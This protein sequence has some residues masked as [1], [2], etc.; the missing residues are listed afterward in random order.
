MRDIKT[1]T[2]QDVHLD[3]LMKDFET[4][5]RDLR[6]DCSDGRI[7]TCIQKQVNLVEGIV[8]Q[9]PGVKHDN[10]SRICDELNSFGT[11]PHKDIKGSIKNLYSFACDYPGIRHSGEPSRAIRSIE[12]RDMVAISILLTGF[13][14]Y[15]MYGLDADIV[16]RGDL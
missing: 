8:R 11:W 14:P 6:D 7:K 5:I 15:L 12:M 9:Y 4:A 2:S 10:I 1:A 13:M 16:Y 3:S